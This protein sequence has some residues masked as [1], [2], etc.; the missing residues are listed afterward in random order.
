MASL[1]ELP[2]RA[3]HLPEPISWW[4][5]AFGW[6]LAL[7]A[8][9]LLLLAGVVILQRY[10]KPALRK[11]AS[12]MLDQIEK[13]FQENEDAS[14]CLSELSKL[15]RR[16]VLSQN[17]SLKIAGVTGEAWLELLDQPLSQKEFSQGPGRILLSGPY[18]P[19]VDK[20]EAAVLIQLCRKWV[21][22]L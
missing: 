1:M 18:L 11:E 19:Q 9:F 10:L 14:E 7:G 4:P 15:L 2:L 3:I 21:K 20:G 5:P 12:K 16:A 22:T 13:T 17:K 6:W 8:V